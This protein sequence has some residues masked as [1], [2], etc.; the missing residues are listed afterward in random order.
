M[1]ESYERVGDL[2][3]TLS[4]LVRGN[5]N[6]QAINL[7]TV[8]EEGLLPLVSADPLE[9]RQDFTWYVG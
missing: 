8:V 2:A 5:E 4:L 1:E 7:S 6:A 9:K 3:E